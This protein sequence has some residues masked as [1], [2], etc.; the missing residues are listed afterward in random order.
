MVFGIEVHDAA[1]FAAVSCV[2]LATA[3]LA[4]GL[5]ARQAAAVEP[6]DA[7]RD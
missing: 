5:P 3:S 7:L 2:A 4:A 1:T 6:I